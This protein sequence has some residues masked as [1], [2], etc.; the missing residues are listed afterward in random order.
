MQTQA[1]LVR[2]EQGSESTTRVK[3]TG[4]SKLRYKRG[5]HFQHE[6][7]AMSELLN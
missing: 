2:Q 3:S 7:G 5:V 6:Y 4:L 1:K